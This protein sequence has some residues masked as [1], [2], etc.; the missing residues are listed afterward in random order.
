MCGCVG[1]GESESLEI[2]RRDF[3]C[4]S[5]DEGPVS[6][7]ER[8]AGDVSVPTTQETKRSVALPRPLWPHVK[9]VRTQETILLVSS[10]CGNAQGLAM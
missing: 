1:E 7:E 9:T 6:G 10:L 4:R 5:D 2:L 3:F 8:K